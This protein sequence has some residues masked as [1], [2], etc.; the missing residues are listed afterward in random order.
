MEKVPVGDVGQSF[1]RQPSKLPRGHIGSQGRLPVLQS[2]TFIIL[3]TEI[4]ARAHSIVDTEPS[5]AETV[6]VLAKVP[7]SHVP[8]RKCGAARAQRLWRSGIGV[9]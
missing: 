7:K 3:V 8:A 1:K 9:C 6:D 5:I 4:H 2:L